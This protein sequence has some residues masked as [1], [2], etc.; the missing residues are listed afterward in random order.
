MRA[1]FPLGMKLN[2]LVLFVA[3]SC[4]SAAE[5]KPLLAS[6]DLPPYPAT[7]PLPS[8]LTHTQQGTRQ[9]LQGLDLASP[10]AT[11]EEQALAREITGLKAQLPDAEEKAYRDDPSLLLSDLYTEGAHTWVV[12]K[13]NDEFN[14]SLNFSSSLDQG[15]SR[16][17]KKTL[18]QAVDLI[19][20]I[21]FVELASD[22]KFPPPVSVGLRCGRNDTEEGRETCTGPL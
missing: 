12:A 7:T 2:G 15:E 9:Q 21:L 10:N 16:R 5:L 17:R 14:A 1:I 19:D 22:E 6:D 20:M 13:H 4:S 3:L 8:E 11:S 18:H